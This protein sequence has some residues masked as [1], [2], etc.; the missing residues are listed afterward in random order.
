MAG[1]SLVDYNLAYQKIKGATSVVVPASELAMAEKADKR[2]PSAEAAPV[3]TSTATRLPA[4]DQNEDRI[5]R[6][7]QTSDLMW[8]MSNYKALDCEN[9]GMK[10]KLP[11]S[12][13]DSA[14]R[15]P[16]CG[17]INQV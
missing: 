5:D 8:R 6:T 7:R 14:V 13:T 1:A 15:C 2:I 16:R 11:P 17:H 10:I 3:V 9:C 4:P 12:Y